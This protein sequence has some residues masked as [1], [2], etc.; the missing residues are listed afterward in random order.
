MENKLRW[1]RVLGSTSGHKWPQGRQLGL[2]RR[3]EFE[4]RGMDETGCE[5]NVGGGKETQYAT[6]RYLE[7]NLI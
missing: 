3:K 2:Q 1:E 5:E 4:G 6:P 7:H